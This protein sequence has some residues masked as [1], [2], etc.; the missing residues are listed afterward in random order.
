M[1]PASCKARQCALTVDVW[2]AC[3]FAARSHR[4]IPFLGLF[5]QEHTCATNRVVFERGECF[6]GVCE[7]EGLDVCADGN[8][9]GFLQ[10]LM[11]V[12]ACVVGDAADDALA[13]DERIIE[14][15]DRTHVYAAEH[16]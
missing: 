11:T 3:S 7:R 6:V 10:K 9:R 13:I 4:S 1:M 15:R 2:I 5:T 8:L 14:C 12:C 16:K